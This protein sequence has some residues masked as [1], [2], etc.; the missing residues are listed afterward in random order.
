MQTTEVTQKQWQDII[1]NNPATSNLGDL[2]P[3]ESV[4]W[5]EAA[6]F[7]NTLSQDEGRSG[8][9]T[10]TGCSSTPGNGMECTGISINAG[11]SGYRLPTEAEWEYAARATTTTAYAN[12]VDFDSS[13]TETSSGFNSNLHA[14]GWYEFNNESGDLSR[15]VPGYPSGTKPVAQKQANRWGLYDLHGN[16]LE[17]CQDEF[18][19]YAGDA[20]DP[21]GHDV[22]RV[23]RGGYWGSPAG[24]ARSAQR[25][26]GG[27]RSRFAGRGFRLVLPPGQ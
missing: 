12:P 15:D 21:R 13:N 3:L 6:F 9:Y 7:A 23:N 11:C 18:A 19:D 2:Y 27:P 24:N 1:G 14:M 16:V 22:S 25:F 20:T 10:L 4:N 26:G 5:F 8:C 17:W